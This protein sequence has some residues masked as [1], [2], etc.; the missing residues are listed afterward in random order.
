MTDNRTELLDLDRYYEYLDFIQECKFKKYESQLVMHS[1]HVIPTFIDEHNDHS[2]NRVLLSV[3]D[4]IT[5]HLKLADCFDE[6]SYERH[7]NIASAN[8]LNRSS[9][10]TIP[11]LH[12]VYDAQRGEGNPA[13]RPEVREKIKEGIRNYYENN[14]NPKKGK[15]YE[16]IYGVEGAEQQRLKRKKTTRTP[17][18]YKDA[19]KKISKSLKGKM[20]GSKNGFARKIKV[21]GVYYG[22]VV[23]ACR[24]LN[25]SKYK[26]YKHNKIEDVWNIYT[27]TALGAAHAKH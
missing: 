19:A 27:F 6:G 9:I 3:D 21:N 10:R 22:S 20:V 25:I 11:N 12:E 4:H 23:E 14:D 26:L 16:D 13:K 2:D 7:G 1:H 18:E 15:S 24:T 5:A 17:S 8:L